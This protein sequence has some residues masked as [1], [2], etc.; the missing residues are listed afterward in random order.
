MKFWEQASQELTLPAV[1]KVCQVWDR[2][3][4][5]LRCYTQLP[6]WGYNRSI[7][8]LRKSGQFSNFQTYFSSWLHFTTFRE[9]IYHIYFT[10]LI[11]TSDC[12][13]AGAYTK[14][15]RGH[16]GYGQLF[17]LYCR[18]ALLLVMMEIIRLGPEE[19]TKPSRPNLWIPHYSAAQGFTLPSKHCQ[20]WA[21]QMF[22]YAWECL[23]DDTTRG[24]PCTST[25]WDS[26]L[27]FCTLAWSQKQVP[28][29]PADT[30]TYAG[31][32]L[33]NYC[34]LFNTMQSL[35]IPG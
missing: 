25:K 26:D 31:D 22:T 6:N 11:S 13:Q 15:R 1:Q 20:E 30:S 14:W 27:V 3:L 2:T 18:A 21:L 33:L 34:C 29:S 12:Q 35:E 17:P 19:A 7:T 28:R 9:D 16:P 8:S 5:E 10:T 32:I 24:Q 4:A 23:L